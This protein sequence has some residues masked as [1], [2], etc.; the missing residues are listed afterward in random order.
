[1]SAR[2]SSLGVMLLMDDAPVAWKD[3]LQERVRQ[4]EVEGFDD[5]HDD[6]HSGWEI[7]AA[8]AAY[9]AEAAS[10]ARG[11]TRAHDAGLALWPWDWS[12]WKP[13]DYRRMLVKAGALIL[14]AIERID[15]NEAK[16]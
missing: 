13:G 8:G 15:R 7:M 10:Q 4:I 6:Q 16:R 1:M 3:V 14:A 5:A 9:A 12:W 2:R 11:P